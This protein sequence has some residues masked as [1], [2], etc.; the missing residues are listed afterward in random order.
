VLRFFAEFVLVQSVNTLVPN[1]ANV[2]TDIDQHRRSSIT[3]QL[4]AYCYDVNGGTGPS[5]CAICNDPRIARGDFL[6]IC[7]AHRLHGEKVSKCLNSVHLSCVNAVFGYHLMKVRFNF[8]LVLM[9]FNSRR[10]ARASAARAAATTGSNRR[11][12]FDLLSSFLPHSAE[13]VKV[14]T[15][16]T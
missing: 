9:F 10:P 15:T 2:C 8:D 16:P 13:I 12:V 7:S 1:V 4:V 14:P 3:D 11:Y 6:L 5:V